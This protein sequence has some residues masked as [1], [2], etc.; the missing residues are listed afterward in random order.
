MLKINCS[1]LH[2]I[3]F[4]FANEYEMYIK[5]KVNGGTKIFS[6]EDNKY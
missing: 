2:N 1:H 6:L 5:Y 4:Y 3:T